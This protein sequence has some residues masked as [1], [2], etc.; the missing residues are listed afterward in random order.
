MPLVAQAMKRN[1]VTI[2]G[3]IRVRCII[4]TASPLL[5]DDFCYTRDFLALTLCR[6]S[7]FDFL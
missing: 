4:S 3:D 5:E 2:K 6:K 7:G 1:G